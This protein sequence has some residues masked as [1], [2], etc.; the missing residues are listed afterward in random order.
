MLSPV[1]RFGPLV[2]GEQPQGVV[3]LADHSIG[4]DFRALVS[5]DALVIAAW[6]VCGGGRR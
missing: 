5:L 2:V 1:R 3:D 6:R 4:V